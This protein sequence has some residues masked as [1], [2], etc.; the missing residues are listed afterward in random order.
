[1]GATKMPAYHSSL[2]DPD[3]KLIGNMA[4]LPIRKPGFP[5]NAIYAKPANKQED[6]VMRAYLTAT[7]TRDWTETLQ[8]SKLSR[9]H[10]LQDTLAISNSS[11]LG[12]ATRPSGWPQHLVMSQ[13]RQLLKGCLLHC[14]TPPPS[15]SHAMG[16]T[17][18]TQLVA[19]TNKTDQTDCPQAVPPKISSKCNDVYSSENPNAYQLA[20]AC[21]NSSEYKYPKEQEDGRRE[22]LL[23]NHQKILI[24]FKFCQPP[25][26]LFSVPMERISLYNN[27]A[28][29]CLPSVSSSSA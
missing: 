14:R 27:F 15:H 19:Q 7:E 24:N 2:M 23:C 10:L 25:A 22:G 18:V 21:C 26:L 12:S 6:E 8:P 13:G 11:A 28:K 9:D 29:M 4:L 3:T 20:K 17:N 1:M 16:Q 5:L